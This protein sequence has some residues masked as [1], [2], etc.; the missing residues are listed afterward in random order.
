[1]K[2]IVVTGG[3]KGIGRA[4][5]EDL[6]EQ[7]YRVTA[8]FHASDTEAKT[9]TEKYEYVNFIQVNLEDRQELDKAIDEL[10]RADPIDVLINNAGLYV[11]KA[12]EKMSETELY[13]Q[14]DLNIVA[15]AR[16]IQGLLPSLHKSVA[17]LVINI[18]S[19]AGHGRLTGEA[20]YSAVKAAISTLSYVLRA[21]L[22]PKGVRVTAVEP[23]G[24]NTYDI[25]EPSDML[26]PRELAE[27]VRNIIEQPDHIQLDTVVVSHIR[28]SR[29]DYPEWVEQ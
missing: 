18:S 1:M 11:G 14:S 22:N 6:A 16:L 7:G 21:E 12:F 15:P 26:L 5:V 24:V 4:I 27:V 23:Y 9:L 29:P 10:L 3:A 25:P 28:Q 20:M 17:P 13:Q 19:Q 2:H 8:T